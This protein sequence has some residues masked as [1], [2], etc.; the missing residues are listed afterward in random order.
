MR[1]K[2]AEVLA[3]L[4]KHR[5]SESAR[6]PNSEKFALT[7]WARL[8]DAA[9]P[10]GPPTNHHDELGRLLNDIDRALVEVGIGRLERKTRVGALLPRCVTAIDIR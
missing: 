10:D 8:R 6:A 2:A 5:A 1:R 7:P 9:W 3:A 4:M